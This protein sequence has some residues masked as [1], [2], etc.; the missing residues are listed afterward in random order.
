[1]MVYSASS[2]DSGATHVPPPA[3]TSLDGRDDIVWKT[4]IDS[5]KYSSSDKND[6]NDE[7][8]HEEFK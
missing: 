4:L 5:S 7:D 2:L 8:L 6:T 3:P 1:M